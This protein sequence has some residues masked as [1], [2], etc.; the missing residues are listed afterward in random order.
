MSTTDPSP[1]QLSAAQLYAL[2]Q[3]SECRG[4]EEC[5]WCCSPC[6]QLWIH[7]DPP[8]MIGVK[9]V[10]AKRPGNQHICVG[11]WLF[12][13]RRTTIKF[14]S[15]KLLDARC[16]CNFPL[17]I[18]R[19]DAHAIDYKED[20]EA[21]YKMLLSP[22]EELVL[23]LLDGSKE[24][25]HLQLMIYNNLKDAK[26]DTPIH[27]T[28]N[29]IP[30][31]YTVYELTEAIKSGDVEGKSPGVAALFRLLGEYQF[32]EVKKGVGRPTKEHIRPIDKPILTSSK[33]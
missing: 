22:D 2:S 26:A 27:F 4:P 9:R 7:D 11:C 21:L 13:R 25:N 28:L 5:H 24:A 8:P 29:N 14:L 3:S 17:V 18:T 19:K 31:N 12:R 23:A 15:G 16:L 30:H 33:K 32:P 20:K 6:A 1:K 10:L